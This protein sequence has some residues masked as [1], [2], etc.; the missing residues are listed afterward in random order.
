IFCFSNAKVQTLWGGQWTSLFFTVATVSISFTCP[1]T[2]N[3]LVLSDSNSFQP[4]FVD[5]S[6]CD[7]FIFSDGIY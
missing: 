7:S 1:H 2:V 4:L 5:F 6:E 3:L